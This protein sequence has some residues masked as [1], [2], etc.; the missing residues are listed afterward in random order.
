M[1]GC[2]SQQSVGG[3]SGVTSAQHSSQWHDD[4][5]AANEQY[6]ELDGNETIGAHILELAERSLL[7]EALLSGHQQ[8]I[9][10]LELL[11][12]HHSRHPVCLLDWQHL[13][14]HTLPCISIT[15]MVLFLYHCNHARCAALRCTLLSCAAGSVSTDMAVYVLCCHLTQQEAHVPKAPR[16]YCIDAQ[17]Q[18]ASAY[19]HTAGTHETA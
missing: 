12:W 4:A 16:T 15:S 2:R 1:W 13:P 9:L 7:D 8:V 3:R 17:E 10:L 11:H 19:K 5:A 18:N 6:L 14:H